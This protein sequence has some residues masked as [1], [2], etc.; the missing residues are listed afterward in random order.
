QKTTSA[1]AA[2]DL[3]PGKLGPSPGN[4]ERQGG[5]TEGRQR[6]RFEMIRRGRPSPAAAALVAAALAAAGGGRLRRAGGVDAFSSPGPSGGR[7]SPS[8]SSPRSVAPLRVR[9][10]R[11]GYRL[12]VSDDDGSEAAVDA[13][14]LGDEADV[15]AEASA[16]AVFDGLLPSTTMVSSATISGRTRPRPIVGGLSSSALLLLPLLDPS[17]P[18]LPPTAASSRTRPLFQTSAPAAPAT[19]TATWKERLVDVSNLASLLCVLDCTLLPLVSVA[20]PAL[21]WGAELVAPAS[22]L[23]GAGGARPIAAGLSSLLASLPALSH[24]IALYFVIPVG[25]LTT[26]VNYF[27]GHREARF[28]LASLLGVA[29]IYAAN[30]HAGVGIPSVDA[31]LRSVGVASAAGGHAGHVHDACGAV[32]GAAT[33]MM[34]HTCPEGLAHRATNT[35]GCALLLG[36]NYLSRKYAEE[37]SRGCAAS[38]L[39]EAWGGG[40]GRARS[41]A[42]TDG[43]HQKNNLKPREIIDLGT[44]APLEEGYKHRQLQA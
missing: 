8:L 37:R 12:F 22:G 18:T 20:I 34:A 2:D 35:L 11:R 26:I 36:S 4:P 1:S 25:L 27:F 15:A 28:S 19:A 9:G 40:G 30:S 42:A 29:L 13:T 17:D 6:F 38:A 39:A 7:P 32:V 44:F 33:G 41:T 3:G 21:S 43:P 14:A 5:P 16:E 31:W 24:G 23:A 10:G